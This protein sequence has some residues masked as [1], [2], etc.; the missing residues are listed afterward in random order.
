MNKHVRT[1]LEKL[2]NG[3]WSMII[4]ALIVLSTVLFA[5]KPIANILLVVLMFGVTSRLSYEIAKVI[6]WFDDN[7]HSNV[8]M[9]GLYHL[10]YSVGIC[11]LAGIVIASF[12]SKIFPFP[13]TLYIV[14]D[15]QAIFFV[16]GFIAAAIGYVIAWRTIPNGKKA[17]RHEPQ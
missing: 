10:T 17:G 3:Q 2:S 14:V 13:Q 15:P 11:I 4:I 9:T 5:I 1:Q 12:G 7:I 6:D 16:G 8:E